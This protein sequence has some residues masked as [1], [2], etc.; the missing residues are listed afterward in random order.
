MQMKLLKLLIRITL[1]AVNVSNKYLELMWNWRV[2]GFHG[3]V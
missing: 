1:L 2:D 3:A